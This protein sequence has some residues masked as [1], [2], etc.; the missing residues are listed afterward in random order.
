VD[1][2]D[3]ARFV[4]TSLGSATV[5]TFS[6]YFDGSD[7]GLSTNNENVDA[8][9]VLADGRIVFSTLGS[10]GVPGVSGSDTDLVAFTPTALGTTT[11]GTWAFYFDGSDVGLSDGT[12]EDINGV[13][14][15]DSTGKIYLT[16]AGTFS[17]AGAAGDASDIFVCTPGTLGTTTSCTFSLYWDGSANGFSGQVT[18]GISLS[19]PGV[20]SGLLRQNSA[21][22]DELGNTEDDFVDSPEAEEQIFLPGVSK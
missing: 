9:D 4:P 17:V 13:W 21:G 1:D 18:D 14:V 20:G 2:S 5:G 15:E 8:F 11:S 7:V 19:A 12:A 22:A 10:F 3:I 16:T 6:L